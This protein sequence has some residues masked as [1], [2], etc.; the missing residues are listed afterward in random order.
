MWIPQ[1]GLLTV[2]SEGRGFTSCGKSL[3]CCHSEPAFWRSPP[4]FAAFLHPQAAGGLRAVHSERSAWDQD[5]SATRSGQHSGLRIHQQ[6]SVILNAAA[7]PKVYI[8]M[9]ATHR[10]RDSSGKSPFCGSTA[11]S[12]PPGGR[13]ERPFRESGHVEGVWRQP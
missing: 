1:G 4:W 6:E 9:A 13:T 10:Q 2:G 12:A 8:W 3:Q 7:L 5:D 11:D